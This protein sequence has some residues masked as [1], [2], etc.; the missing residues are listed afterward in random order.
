[1]PVH[2][3]T[4]S[5]LSLCV[6]RGSSPKSTPAVQSDLPRPPHSVRPLSPMLVSSSMTAGSR[7]AMDSIH[8]RPPLLIHVAPQHTW[9]HLARNSATT[10]W[11]AAARRN[12]LPNKAYRAS[13]MSKFD[14][15]RLQHQQPI[16]WIHH[17]SIPLLLP[18]HV[19]RS[20]VYPRI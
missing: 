2:T 17:S 4:L 12:V 3:Y 15:L 8:P 5:A 18:T 9:S 16:T 19:Y 6:A 7:C 20:H 10:H 14:C 11:R 13:D 1:M